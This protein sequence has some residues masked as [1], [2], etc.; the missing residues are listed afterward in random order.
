MGLRWDYEGPL[1][2]K[3]GRLTGFNP[4]AY[5]YNQ[6][7]DT[8]VNSGFE[9]AGNNPTFATPGASKSLLTNHQYGFAPR[10]SASTGCRIRI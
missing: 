4:S 5:S 1:T 7:T 2:E 8:I 10:I 6:S 9:I 3:Y